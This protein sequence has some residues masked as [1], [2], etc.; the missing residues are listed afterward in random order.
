MVTPFRIQKYLRGLRYPVRKEEALEHA[1]G[2]GAEP[3]LLDVL[4]GLE[5]ALVYESPVAL[6]RAL[7]D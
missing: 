6:S 2:L 5:D 3:E 7:S 1:R 4:Q